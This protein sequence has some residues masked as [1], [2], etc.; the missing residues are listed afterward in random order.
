[1]RR[2]LQKELEKAMRD[3]LSLGGMMMMSDPEG[4]ALAT[5]AHYKY[6]SFLF[7]RFFLLFFFVEYVNLYYYSFILSL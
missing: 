4:A 6:F 2:A 7:F 3:N 1:M 5:R